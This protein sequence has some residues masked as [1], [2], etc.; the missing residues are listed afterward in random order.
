MTGFGMGS[1]MALVLPF[2]ITYLILQ[3][4]ILLIW[5]GIGLPLGIG[6]TE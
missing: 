3:T 2:G 6:S 4:T 5:W 1:L